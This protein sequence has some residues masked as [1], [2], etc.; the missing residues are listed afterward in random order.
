M[1][2]VHFPAVGFRGGGPGVEPDPVGSEARRSILFPN[3]LGILKSQPLALSEYSFSSAHTDAEQLWSR[4]EAAPHQGEPSPLS[5]ARALREPTP[6]SIVEG[7]QEDLY[8]G[9]PRYPRN[10]SGLGGAEPVA[11][12]NVF[13][14]DGGEIFDEQQEMVEE[15]LDSLDGPEEF[16]PTNCLERG[17][18]WIMDGQSSE[19]P[20][21]SYRMNGDHDPHAMVLERINRTTD[22][23]S[24]MVIFLNILFLLQIHPSSPLRTRWDFYILLLVLYT[25]IAQPYIICFG[26]DTTLVEHPAIGT[27]ELVVDCSFVLDIYL[28][29]RT[30]YV[31]EQGKIVMGRSSLMRNYCKTWFGIDVVSVMPWD[32]VLSSKKLGFLQLVKAARIIKLMK[33]VKLLK[34]VK[35]LRVIKVPTAFESIEVKFGRAF[36]RMVSFFLAAIMTLHFTGCVFHY[37]AYLHDFK[38]TWVTLANLEES[39]NFE[40]YVTALY[41]SMSTMTTVGY[42]DVIP[43]NV[44][45]KLA[46]MIGMMVG[47]T[48]FGYFMGS[49]SAMLAAW[50]TSS[51]RMTAKR[52]IVDDF[53]RHRKIPRDLSTRVRN[54]Y[55]YV[56]EREVQKDESDIIRGLSS[57]LQQEVLLYL[58]R[59]TLEKV[60]FFRGKHP[61]FITMLVQHLKLEFCAPGEY[62]VRE[63]DIGSEMYF[64]AEGILEVRTYKQMTGKNARS[65]QGPKSQINEVEI[66]AKADGVSALNYPAPC[67]GDGEGSSQYRIIRRLSSG[68]YFGVRS[69]ILRSAHQTSVMAVKHCEL[70]SLSREDLTK[71]MERW[72]DLAEQLATVVSQKRDSPPGR[73]SISH[74]M[75]SMGFHST[76]QQAEFSLP[77]MNLSSDEVIQSKVSDSQHFQPKSKQPERDLTPTQ[78]FPEF[79]P[80]PLEHSPRSPR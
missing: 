45:E 75:R 14:T 12:A 43:G 4:N 26:I 21:T 71:C 78:E 49:M 27:L 29:I 44:R 22:A 58:Y 2:S 32:L 41:W 39:S 63:G 69:C 23:C 64:V 73:Q 17:M 57:Q 9:S 65:R 74:V 68:M 10:V 34:M 33:I 36:V 11:D 19:S 8:L 31:N 48:A 35:L 67:S 40:R 20:Q 24:R 56:T 5:I 30:G 38:D 59:E 15:A 1:S 6:R 37:V 72:P 16:I 50:S 76:T 60:P 70:Y 77:V 66:K 42:G 79:E 54:F 28:N 7:N 18:C 25:C 55:S 52:Q 80:Y 53:L 3:D 46:S 62:V 13:V 61:Q 47:I 51:S